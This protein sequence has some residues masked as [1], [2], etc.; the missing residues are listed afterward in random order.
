MI[1]N[2]ATKEE[3]ILC[4]GIE[5]IEGNKETHIWKQIKTE[6]WIENFCFHSKEHQLVNIRTQYQSINEI[7][8][9]FIKNEIKTRL[10]PNP[11]IQSTGGKYRMTYFLS[12]QKEKIIQ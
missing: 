8:L 11:S 5:K 9:W 2:T 7:L 6:S 3:P 12:N 4:L 10:I 1:L